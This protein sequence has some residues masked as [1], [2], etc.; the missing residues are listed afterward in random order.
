MAKNKKQKA[1]SILAE[2]INSYEQKLEP[3]FE[4][5]YNKN[6]HTYIK[7]FF[8]LAEE[9][10]ADDAKEKWYAVYEVKKT[11]PID[12]D[13]NDEPF[14]CLEPGAL[15]S[16]EIALPHQARLVAGYALY[17]GNEADYLKEALAKQYLEFKG[18]RK[19]PVLDEEFEEPPI[20]TKVELPEEED[21]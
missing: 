7:N 18:V 2:E 21:D 11:F 20:L 9:L 17:F 12:W 4:L 16:V 6:G 3:K 5:A 1:L 10:M 15:Y 14:D 8:A 13:G 19:G